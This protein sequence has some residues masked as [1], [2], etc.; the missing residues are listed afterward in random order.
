MERSFERSHVK[1]KVTWGGVGIVAVAILVLF[2]F[3]FDV[4]RHW[5]AIHIGSTK[6]SGPYYGFWSGFGSDIS[7]GAIAVGLYTGLRKVNCHSRMCWRIGHHPLEGT[8]YHLCK[9]HHPDVPKHSARLE[10]ILAQYQTYKDSQGAAA[11]A[12]PRPSGAAAAKKAP[13][14]KAV[15]RKVPVKR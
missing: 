13:A 11:P 15:A 4:L 6:E 14:K 8:P 9:K 12:A 1:L 10:D 7:E 2:I 3:N 5:T